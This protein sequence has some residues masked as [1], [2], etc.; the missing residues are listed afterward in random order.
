MV[1][2]PSAVRVGV[3]RGVSNSSQQSEEFIAGCATQ[4]VRIVV[5]DGQGLYLPAGSRAVQ[6]EP[7]DGLSVL[8][9]YRR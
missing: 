4:Q 7:E 6:Q 8:G 5:L 2:L 9:K 1:K 3:E